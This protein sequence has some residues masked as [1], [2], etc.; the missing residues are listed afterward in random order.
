[1]KSHAERHA[2]IMKRHRECVD[3][4]SELNPND[5]SLAAVQL[6]AAANQSRDHIEADQHRNR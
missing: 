5:H 6:R 4:A 2:E 1:M 3:A